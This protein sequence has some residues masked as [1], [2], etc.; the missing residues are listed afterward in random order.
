[1]GVAKADSNWRRHFGPFR[2]T[3]EL[4][5]RVSASGTVFMHDLPAVRGEEVD[6]AVLDGPQSLV[7]V[8]AQH[9]MFSAMSVLEWCGVGL[10]DEVS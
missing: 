4:M 3:E 9:K 8:Q 7:W 10:V 2:V 6:E 1:M 5:R